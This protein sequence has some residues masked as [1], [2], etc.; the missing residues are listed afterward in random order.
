[1]K[2]FERLHNQ[3]HQ[4]GIRSGEAHMRYH[5]KFDRR[6]KRTTV[7]VADDVVYINKPPTPEHHQEAK[8]LK[9]VSSLK[10][11]P[12]KFDP[13]RVVRATPYT[14]TID[15]DAL[16]NIVTIDTVTLA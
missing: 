13:Y 2:A 7:F 9:E 15:M 11:R 5:E 3:M 16:H 10:L 14:V 4:A 6:F 8:N 12:K 1:M